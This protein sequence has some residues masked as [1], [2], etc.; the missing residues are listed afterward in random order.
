MWILTTS[1]FVLEKKEQEIIVYMK[2]IIFK[3]RE[4]KGKQEMETLDYEV[5]FVNS[6]LSA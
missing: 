6:T 5:I 2:K 4:P 3:K 1:Y